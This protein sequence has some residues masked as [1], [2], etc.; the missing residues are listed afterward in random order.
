MKGYRYRISVELLEDVQGHPGDKPP[1]VF[2][3]RN[4]DEL[5]GLVQRLRSRGDFDQDTSASLLIGLKLFSEV[6]LQNRQH[7]LFAPLLPHFGQ[8]MQ[9]LK[10]GPQPD[11]SEPPK[12]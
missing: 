4:H 8:F 6:M 11:T 1:L 2:E 10:Q 12:N 9:R 5:L 7:P 3:C